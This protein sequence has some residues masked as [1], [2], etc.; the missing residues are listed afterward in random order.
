MI[1]QKKRNKFQNRE[2]YSNLFRF[3]FAEFNLNSSTIFFFFSSIFSIHN[4]CDDDSDAPIKSRH[5]YIARFL[6]GSTI[7]RQIR[8]LCV[9]LCVLYF[10]SFIIKK[11]LRKPHLPSITRNT[12]QYRRRCFSFLLF[13]FLFCSSVFI[14]SNLIWY[15]I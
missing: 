3:F 12:T 8:F 4:D 10:R 11:G 2:M 7:R 15:V 9:C 1:R 13:F 14:S 6:F 5:V